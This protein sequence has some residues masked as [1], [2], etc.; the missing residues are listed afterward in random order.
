MSSEQPHTNETLEVRDKAYTIWRLLIWGLG[1][2][3]FVTAVFWPRSFDLLDYVGSAQEGFG[4]VSLL[5]ARMCTGIALLLVLIAFVYGLKAKRYARINK[6][7]LLGVLMLGLGPLLSSFLGSSPKFSVGHMIVPLLF[8]A[9]LL[10]PPMPFTLFQQEVKRLILFYA[11]GSFV[12][13]FV[14][15][16][17]AVETDYDQGYFSWMT[18]RLHGLAIHANHLAPFFWVYLS[19]HMAF[20]PRRAL[21]RINF[22]VVLVAL[23]RWATTA[24]GATFEVGWLWRRRSRAAV[25][26]AG[27]LALSQA[28][29]AL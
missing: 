25:A 22:V 29:E 9:V 17:W 7:L 27:S 15:P 3:P 11:Y 2:I 6:G 10:L 12:A 18:F 1:L 23:V 24:C 28:I 5:I 14:A 8:G 19:L 4:G 21:D 16:D 20:K 26:R 13:A